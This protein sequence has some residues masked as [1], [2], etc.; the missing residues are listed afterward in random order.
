MYLIYLIRLFIK[1]LLAADVAQY[2]S[3]I[4]S[5]LADTGELGAYTS[6][7]SKEVN[8]NSARKRGIENDELPIKVIRLH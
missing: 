4:K 3:K 6:L 5:K 2:P 1:K 8:W 7:R